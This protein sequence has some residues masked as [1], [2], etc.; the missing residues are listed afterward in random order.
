MRLSR[1]VT[2]T[3]KDVSDADPSRNAQLLTQAGFINK[4]MSGVYSYMPL[5]LRT[6][7]KIE[8]IIREEMGGLGA[9]EILM[10][11]LQPRDNWDKTGRWDQID[12]LFKLKGSGDREL[13]L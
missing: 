11:A 9:Q 4:L 1:L 8:N 12:V 5:G 2:R 7:T 13:A 10:P 6:L 3:Q